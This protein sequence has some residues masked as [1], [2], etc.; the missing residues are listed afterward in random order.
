MEIIREAALL[1]DVGKIGIPE[2]ILNKTTRLTDEEFDVMKGHVMNSVGIIRHLPSLDYVI[3]AVVSHHER[4]DGRGYPRK[5]R[6][7]EIPLFG[8]ILCI[9]DAFDAMTSK[10]SYKEA[11]STDYALKEIIENSGTQFDPHLA[12]IFAELV[13]NGDIKVNGNKEKTAKKS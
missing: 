4:W 11:F 2:E 12:E 10:R 1:H 6:G 8:R 13:R 5:L 3:P 7:E 9:A